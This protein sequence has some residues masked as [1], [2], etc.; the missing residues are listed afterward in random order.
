MLESP[1]AGYPVPRLADAVEGE[2][3][4]ADVGA[5]E[6]VVDDGGDDVLPVGAERYLALEEHALLA[7]AVEHEH[8]VAA[9]DGGGPDGRP[10]RRYGAVA[11]VVEDDGRAGCIAA[12]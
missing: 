8:V 10:Q 11:A 9:G 5:V 3:G 12:G 1:G 4:G 2:A 6:E 7:G